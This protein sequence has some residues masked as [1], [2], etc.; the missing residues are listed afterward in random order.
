MFLSIYFCSCHV[1]PNHVLCS[2]TRLSVEK[3]KR[4]QQ[5]ADAIPSD[6]AKL[7]AMEVDYDLLTP[8]VVNGAI[9]P[10]LSRKI[11]DFIGED[12]PTLVNFICSKISAKSPP[13]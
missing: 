6:K 11:T 10:W 3:K 9:R 13:Q 12:E 8:L 5:I 4:Q 1:S 7:F 2:S